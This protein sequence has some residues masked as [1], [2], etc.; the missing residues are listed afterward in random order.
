MHPVPCC[1]APG[2]V[3]EKE[4]MLSHGSLFHG[5]GGFALAARW[6]GIPT[7]W[8]CEIDEYCHK[9]SKQNFPEIETRYRDI[10]EMLNEEI[11]IDPVSIISAG[12][13]CPPFS[14]A[15]KRKGKRDDRYLWPE[16]FEVIKKV[17]PPWVILENVPG[18][19][20]VA[21][22]DVLTNLE[23]ENYQHETFIVP[24]ISVG[25]YHRRDRVWIIAHA[26]GLRCDT[27]RPE[28]SLQGPGAYGKASDS[29]HTHSRK[30]S[31]QREYKGVGRLQQPDEKGNTPDRS[32]NGRPGPIET[33]KFQGKVKE[34]RKQGDYVSRPG[35]E[36]R[37]QWPTESPVCQSV[38]G[39]PSRVDEI[40]GSGNA[41]VPQIAYEIFKTI[42][43]VEKEF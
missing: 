32:C 29:A 28:Q 33:G 7:V 22:E 18:I 35:A 2:D 15:G 19:I 20:N 43:G 40:K 39:I 1:R 5:I 36:G 14:C 42:L 23:S 27:G 13:P 26:G 38:N 17:R 10:R 16:T 6:C 41:I 30:R 25:A 12:F 8:E 9:L 3:G 24:A 21:L 4:E 31:Q 34:K 11:K 37:I